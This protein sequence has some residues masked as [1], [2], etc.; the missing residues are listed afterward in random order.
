[1]AMKERRQNHTVRALIE[2]LDRR[3]RDAERLRNHLTQRPHLIWPDR[4]RQGRIPHPSED[5]PDAG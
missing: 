2:E 3:L 5:E 1:M 4:R